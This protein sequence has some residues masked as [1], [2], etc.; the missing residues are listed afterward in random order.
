VTSS[1]K[2]DSSASFELAVVLPLGVLANQ[3]TKVESELRFLIAKLSRYGQERGSARGEAAA[4]LEKMSE[5]VDAIR[6]LIA[7][8]QAD[9]Q[10]QVSGA[11]SRTRTDR[12]D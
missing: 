3:L 11:T 2:S 7:Q 12:D 9:I 1:A 5:A 4:R 8:I 10:P 6:Q